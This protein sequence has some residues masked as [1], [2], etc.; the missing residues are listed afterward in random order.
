[1]TR[2]T[3]GQDWGGRR[4]MN[5]DNC[6]VVRRIQVIVAAVKIGVKVKREGQGMW[7]VSGAGIEKWFTLGQTNYIALYNLQH[8][9]EFRKKLFHVSGG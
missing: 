4:K 7:W 9:D 2:N 8:F 5:P 1:M 6:P 3:M